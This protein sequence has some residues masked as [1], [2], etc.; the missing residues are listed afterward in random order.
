VQAPADAAHLQHAPG[1]PCE[2]RKQVGAIE[3]LHDYPG[4]FHYSDDFV[5]KRYAQSKAGETAQKI[6]LKLSFTIRVIA[7]IEA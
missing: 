6:R 5:Y 7:P 4:A 1:P 2:V 3:P